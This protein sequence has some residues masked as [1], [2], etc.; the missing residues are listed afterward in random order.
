MSG[1]RVTV[2][3]VVEVEDDAVALEGRA[4]SEGRRAARELYRRAL[5]DADR[6]AVEA[7][8]GARQRVEHRWVATLMGHVRIGRYRVRTD[9][10]T[11]RPLD[12]RLALHPGEA[13][14]GVRA[15]VHR[16]AD[17]LSTREIA[18]VVSEVTGTSFSRYAV[19]RVLHQDPD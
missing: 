3:L 2:E 6:R 7:S 8:G 17:R 12:E 16:L 18:E 1:T 14:P 15:L 19:L 9:H 11:H 10:R 4:V 5:A 13:S